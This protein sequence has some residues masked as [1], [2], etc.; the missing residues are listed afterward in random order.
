[1]V[2]DHY[3]LIMSIFFCVFLMMS[4]LRV[5]VSEAAWY[6]AHPKCQRGKIKRHKNTKSIP[7]SF[8]HENL[9]TGHFL[10]K[11]MNKNEREKMFFVDP[12]R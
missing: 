7:R 12:N 9:K 6:I 8:L 11:I 2:R 5:V 4:Q 3:C 1:M 10:L